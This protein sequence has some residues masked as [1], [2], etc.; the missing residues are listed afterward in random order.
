MGSRRWVVGLSVVL[1]MSACDPVSPEA[2]PVPTTPEATPA[3]APSSAI[4]SCADINPR[5]NNS[6]STDL[7]RSRRLL[8][9]R[10]R[11]PRLRENNVTIRYRDDP[12]CRRNPE[13]RYL[14]QSAGAGLEIAGCL[15]LPK[16]PPK[17]M[18]RVEL[19]FGDA[20]DHSGLAPTLVVH[21]DIPATDAIAAATLR[22]WIDGPTE[23][24]VRAGAYPSA[25]DE[26]EL[27][28]LDIDDG[29]AVVDLN[30]AFER[31]GLGTTYEGAI[32][33]HLAGT[34]TQFDGVD[35][36]L[37][38][39][40]GA[41]K[42]YYMGHG[43]M[44]DPDHPLVRSSR[45]SYRV[46][47]LCDER[48]HVIPEKWTALEERRYGVSLLHPPDWEPM[49]GTRIG[50]RSGFV[51]VDAVNGRYGWSPRLPC[52]SEARH[53]LDPYGSRHRIEITTAAGRAACFVFPS[54]DQKDPQDTSAL[55][56][57]YPQAVSIDGHKY[58]F[59][60]VWADQ[61][62]IRKIARTILFFP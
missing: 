6:F 41:A 40:D 13:T 58:R 18:A 61:Q 24:E 49:H 56:V 59:L 29:T 43:F 9:L 23:E 54:E 35:E 51:Q 26:T 31:T 10:Y 8:H 46:A 50:A 53:K 57:R 22:A 5:L 55:M 12:S 38:K 48:R 14:I 42:D 17:G 60:V 2:A 15:D 20:T 39:I 28:G 1:V 47:P 27:L 3:P 33:S 30:G 62:H 11:A 7:D 36:G 16:E 37:L 32:L 44:V 34:L 25:P 52:R 21:R 45:M 4:V 19:W